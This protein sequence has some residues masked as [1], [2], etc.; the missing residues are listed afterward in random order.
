MGTYT[1]V[2]SQGNHPLVTFDAWG[3]LEEGAGGG[4]TLRQWPQMWKVGSLP[5]ELHGA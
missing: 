4:L 2:L 5:T 3:S 1:D